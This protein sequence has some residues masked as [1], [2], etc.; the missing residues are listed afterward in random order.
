MGYPAGK[1]KLGDLVLRAAKQLEKVSRPEV[2]R[3]L[4]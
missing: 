2:L 4:V 1:T 3:D